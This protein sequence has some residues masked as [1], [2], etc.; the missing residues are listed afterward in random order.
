[1][2][3]VDSPSIAVADGRADLGVGPWVAGPGLG[4]RLGE[5]LDRV[6]GNARRVGVPRKDRYLW[7]VHVWETEDTRGD[8]DGPLDEVEATA[9]SGL[10]AARGLSSRAVSWPVFLYRLR[11]ASDP[12]PRPIL[13][14]H[15][16]GFSD[17]V[18]ILSSTVISMLGYLVMLFGTFADRGAGIFETQATVAVRPWL[19]FLSR[20]LAMVILLSAATL[21]L[22]LPLFGVEKLLDEE[23]RGW[24][25]ALCDVLS[26]SIIVTSMVLPAAVLSRSGQE[27]YSVG[28]YLL[29][30]AMLAG[31][32]VILVPSWVALSAASLGL[33]AC[34][35][36]LDIT[37]S[38][39]RA[40]RMDPL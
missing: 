35:V 17:L 21:L 11:P 9:F 8:A 39:N 16:V 27:A 12:V 34:V 33:A 40:A 29:V 10:I 26:T 1:M 5:R 23:A 37:G 28:G 2:L 30:L 36:L 13:L 22:F 18:H 15:S 4:T 14:G 19:V 31:S 20:A 7:T 3:W 38:L 25:S 24:A 6:V 32:A